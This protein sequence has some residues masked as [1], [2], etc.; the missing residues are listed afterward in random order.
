MDKQEGSTE[1]ITMQREK[2]MRI[3]DAC[4]PWGG[5][6]QSGV[7]HS[8]DPVY[9]TAITAGL[10]LGDMNSRDQSGGDGTEGRK[11]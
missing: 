4:F 2:T 6:A 9:S 11:G 3:C 8:E 1:A 5:W 10:P 7:L